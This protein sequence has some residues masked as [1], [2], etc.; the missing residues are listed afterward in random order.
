M[1][2]I[3]ITILLQALIAVL[4][5]NLGY[6]Q[7][8]HYGRLEATADKE[9]N[10]MFQKLGESALL[11]KKALEEGVEMNKKVPTPDE[12]SAE[13]IK[14]GFKCVYTKGVKKTHKK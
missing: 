6:K 8:K 14:N 4:W 13:M 10:N 11:L 5:Y 3:T 9:L 7:G 2:N 1:Y 12:V